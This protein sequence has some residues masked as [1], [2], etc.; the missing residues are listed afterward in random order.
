MC[1]YL[2]ERLEDIQ[3]FTLAQLHQRVLSCESR[4]K[5]T[6]KVVRHN[7]HVVEC[8]QSISDDESKKC[9]LLGWFGQSRPNLWLVSLYSQFKR[10]DMKR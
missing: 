4:R 3:F 9:T 2:K 6:A 10:N 8:D 1:Y 7:V 5:G